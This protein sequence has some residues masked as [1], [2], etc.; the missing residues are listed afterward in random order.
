MSDPALPQ[1]LIEASYVD[2]ATFFQSTPRARELLSALREQAV[3]V[4]SVFRR[5][6]MFLNW[7]KGKREA[8][9]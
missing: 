3:V 9:L 8:V 5:H 1:P 2:D 4:R 6:A 7:K